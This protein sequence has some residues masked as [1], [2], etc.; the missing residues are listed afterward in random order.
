[1]NKQKPSW[2]HRHPI[3]HAILKWLGRFA[4]I[5]VVIALLVGVGGALYVRDTLQ[6]V[7]EVTEEALQSDPSSNMYAANGERIWSSA[8]NRRIYVEYEDLP[9]DYIDM[10]LATEQETFYEDPGFS[11]KGL[12]NAFLSVVKNA[13]GQGPIR[14]GSS[15][16]QQLIKLTV[17]S[18]GAEDR[19]VD[20]K[21][22][23]F[24]LA[25]QLYENYSK[26][27]ILEFY[28][29]KLPLSEGAYGAQTLAQTYYNKP[30]NELS[31]AKLALIAGTGQAPST[32]NVYINPEDAKNRRDTV[33]FLSYEQGI[34][35]QDEYNTAIDEPI[36]DGLMPKDWQEE[37]NEETVIK[38]D[39]YIQETLDQVA[40]M[41]YDLDQTPLQIHT[42]LKPDLNNHIRDLFN[43]HPEYFQDENHQAA[44]TVIE[45]GTGKV[46]A[47]VGGRH[48]T[49]IGGLNQATVTNRSTGSSTKPFVYAAGMEKY[50]WGTNQ[51]FNGSNYRYA[52]TDIWAYNYGMQQIGQTN[53]Q[54]A[55]RKS[56]N[57]PIL[58]AFDQIGSTDVAKILNDLGFPYYDNLTTS[59]ALGL[60]ASTEHVASAFSTIANGGTYR[61]PQYVT[62]IVFPDKSERIIEQDGKQAVQSSTAWQLIHTLKG[63]DYLKEDGRYNAYVEGLPQIMKTGTVAYP[64]GAG[65]PDNTAMDLWTT[66][67][68]PDVSLAV[69]HGYSTP[70]EGGWLYEEY[71]NQRKHSL[72]RE[73]IK[74]AAED[75][76][77]ADWSAPETA[78]KT[79]G[80]GLS[81][82]YKPKNIITSHFANHPTHEGID[83]QTK[84]Y[85][86]SEDD[87]VNVGRGDQ[88]YEQVPDDYELGQWQDDVDDFSQHVDEE[89][90]ALNEQQEQLESDW[91]EEK[92]QLEADQETAQDDLNQ[93]EERYEE[94]VQAIEESIQEAQEQ[95]EERIEEA[96]Q[97]E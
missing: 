70:M 21:I 95:A 78:V 52:G 26:D 23:E 14:G 51:P 54:Q 87:E 9:Q 83:E 61:Q 94:E 74:K 37:Q 69:W 25:N 59:H 93:A 6:D 92:D 97:S 60:N 31:I 17:F 56:Y 44:A 90:Q 36:D 63:V 82:H 86:G 71:M 91:E 53:L 8:K 88:D 81:A 84:P 58:R 5:G 38:Y 15:I 3:M 4:L 55:L 75:Y 28:V 18:T 85:F 19:T 67:A 64:D 72:H 47:Q 43:N 29:N 32:Y 35:T 73:I 12:A 65:N 41:G 34:L 40:A 13:L 33:L 46:I 80:D 89:I 96:T 20:R 45:N 76:E 48:K 66:G 57:T 77:N 22:K 7:P 50:G 39:G 68:T 27:Q 30:L 11:P 16:E 62:K 79:S 42:A 2:R 1:M 49:Q 24:Y 10:L